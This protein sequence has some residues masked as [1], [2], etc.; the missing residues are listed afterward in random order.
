M[1]DELVLLQQRRPFKLNNNAKGPFVFIKYNQDKR[2]TST[3]QIASNKYITVSTTIIC[4]YK[5][6]ENNNKP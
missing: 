2:V 6:L 5:Y 1:R 3:L 4:P